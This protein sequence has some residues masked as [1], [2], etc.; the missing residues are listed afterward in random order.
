MPG[1]VG[2]C[3]KHLKCPHCITFTWLSSSATMRAHVKR[4]HLNE[5]A[6]PPLSSEHETASG[7]DSACAEDSDHEMHSQPDSDGGLYFRFRL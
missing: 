4:Y 1:P 7:C 5:T 6:I 2:L 3:S